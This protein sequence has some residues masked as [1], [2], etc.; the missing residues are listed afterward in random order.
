MTIVKDL[1]VPVVDCGTVDQ[2]MSL[3]EAIRTLKRTQNTLLVLDRDHRVV[4]KLGQTD[5]VTSIYPG[6]RH[7]NGSEA[8]AHT[9]LAGLSPALLNS[10]MQRYSPW[11]ESLEQR[12]QEVLNLKV[13]DCMCTPRTDEYVQDSDS[14]EVAVNQ[15]IA[16]HHQS[17]LVIRGDGIAGVLWLVDVLEQIAFG[18]ADRNE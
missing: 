18:C 4:G 9:S 13:K 6:H 8:I 14:L 16:G 10:L 3:C 11:N 1:M 2:E 7:Q 17:L 12:C 15:F 5:I